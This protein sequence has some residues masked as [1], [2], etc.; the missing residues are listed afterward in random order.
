MFMRR[1]RLLND[2]FPDQRRITGMHD[3]FPEG[4]EIKNPTPII[5]SVYWIV[6]KDP[7][8]SFIRFYKEL[9]VFQL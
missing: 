6:S 7:C 3:L 2:V 9:L 8:R 5:Y 1:E 4:G